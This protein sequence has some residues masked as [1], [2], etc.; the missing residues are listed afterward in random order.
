MTGQAGD[1]EKILTKHMR[2]TGLAFR[3]DKELRQLNKKK[4]SNPIEKWVKDRDRHFPKEYIWMAN[5]HKKRSQ[6]R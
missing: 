3:I 1:W 5:K 4:T 2:N 6:Y